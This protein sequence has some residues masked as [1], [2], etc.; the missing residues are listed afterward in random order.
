MMKVILE[1]FN[2]RLRGKPIDIREPNPG[3]CIEY[4]FSVPYVAPLMFNPKDSPPIA[5]Q[6][7]RCKFE[8]SGRVKTVKGDLCEIF[9]LTGISER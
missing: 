2:G 4:M 7:W 5:S 6:F 9:V 8:T 3:G 1:A